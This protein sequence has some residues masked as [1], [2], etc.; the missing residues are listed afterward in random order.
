MPVFCCCCCFFF[1]FF[2]YGEGR[3]LKD[4]HEGRKEEGALAAETIV[5][6]LCPQQK[7]E[8]KALHCRGLL[9]PSRVPLAQPVEK[10]TSTC[11]A[12]YFKTTF[13]VSEI[14]FLP[15]CLFQ[16]ILG[17]LRHLYLLKIMLQLILGRFRYRYSSL[18]DILDYFRAFLAF[19]TIS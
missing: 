17:Y 12:G 8:K 6:H 9:S 5:F 15:F 11:Y 1:V 13:N 2:L 16:L 19:V 14:I 7:I 3:N 10:M 18:Q 4:A